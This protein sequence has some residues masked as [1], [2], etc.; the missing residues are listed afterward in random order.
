MRAHEL[1]KLVTDTAQ[2]AEAVVLG[3]GSE[4]VLHGGVV[5]ASLLE[6][7]GDN[8]ALVLGRQSGC[9]QD[10]GELGVR[11]ELLAEGV[12]GLCGRVERGALGCCGVLCA[13]WLCQ[14]V[15]PERRV[16]RHTRALA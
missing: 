5:G 8:L 1:L 2:D 11:L 14:S 3:Q 16:R 10:R 15:L 7:L 13:G 6:E 4:E 9:V 12:E